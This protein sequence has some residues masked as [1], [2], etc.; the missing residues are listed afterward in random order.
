M[1]WRIWSC[2]AFFSFF[3]WPQ[4][5]STVDKQHHPLGH[6]TRGEYAERLPPDKTC[7]DWSTF[8]MSYDARW[9]RHRPWI[10]VYVAG[11]P[12]SSRPGVK[13]VIFRDFTVRA[14]Y[15]YQ[16]MLRRTKKLGRIRTCILHIFRLQIIVL[17]KNVQK[18]LFELPSSLI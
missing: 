18:C 12:E 9:L 10:Q 16:V 7:S 17:T 1:Q 4:Y 6:A 11:I 8:R 15:N 13:Y 3:S 2:S 14:I 5:S